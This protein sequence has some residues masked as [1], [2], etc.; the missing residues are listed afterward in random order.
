MADFVTRVLKWLA[1]LVTAYFL[2]FVLCFL[3]LVAAAT[4][5]QPTSPTVEKGSILVMD[6]AMNLS[7]K[8]SA[9]DPLSVI[10]GAL[11]G[12]IRQSV[13]L[14]QVL[15]G[16]EKAKQ[17]S[18]I[19]GLLIEGNL[20]TEG[21][22]GSFATLREVREAIESFA[23][24]KPVWALIKGDSMRDYYLKS[25]ATELYSD[26]FAIVDFRG[27]RAERM[28]LGDALE[29]LGIELQ[30]SAYEEYKT[31]YESFVDNSMSDSEREQVQSVIDDLWASLVG[32]IARTRGVPAEDLNALAGNDMFIYGSDVTEGRLSD[33]VLTRNEFK[34]KLI[35][36][37]GY[38][39]KGEDFL[40]FDFVDYLYNDMPALPASLDLDLGGNKVA[41]LYIEGIIVDGKSEDG[42][43]GAETVIKQLQELRDKSSVKALVIRVN[44][45]GG[46][47]TASTRIAREIESTREKMPVVVSMG[48]VGASGGYMVAAVGDQI[49]VQPTT[50][51]GSI[52]VVSMLPNI[53][54]MAEK[55]SINFESVE[56]HPFAGS[57]SLGRT[58]TDE[59]MRQLR[60]LGAQIY[61]EFMQIVASNRDMTMKEV[62]SVAKGRIWSG[63]AA[64][65]N[66]LADAVGGLA[67][68]IRR[69]ADMA[70]IGN[71]YKVIDRPRILTFEEQIQEM[72]VGSRAD[73][74]GNSTGMESFI[75]DLEWELKRFKTF[76][77]P[78]GQYLILP[79]SLKVY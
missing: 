38:D 43:V 1:A 3:L 69:A 11:S 52:G 68:A 39:A 63:K 44:S 47:S 37:V 15:N 49:F 72:L 30:V 60:A 70:G 24:E 12:E 34:Q 62:R 16:L 42:M 22:G 64:V 76:N 8:P 55:L 18:D 58:K 7:D 67:Q 20:V 73:Y 57:F 56:T 19:Q 77:D 65:E 59:E 6:L 14:R 48:G 21:Y 75:N 31:A 27:L 66:G 54:K 28:Y 32:D 51:T 35:D 2:L 40:Q 46:S 41:V 29:K 4:I 79:Y 78:H 13:S 5:F 10:T 36:R 25:A 45:P 26:P 23:G 53:E 74:F 61:D 33:D 17:D 9:G 50:I 71:D